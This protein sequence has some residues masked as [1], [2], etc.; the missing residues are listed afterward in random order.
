MYDVHFLGSTEEDHVR[1]V[2]ITVATENRSEHLR[3]I[4]LCFYLYCQ[5]VWMQREIEER[6]PFGSKVCPEKV[7]VTQTEKVSSWSCF[8]SGCAGRGPVM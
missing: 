6:F 5:P 7:R 8:G 3:N 4:G 1:H 2:R